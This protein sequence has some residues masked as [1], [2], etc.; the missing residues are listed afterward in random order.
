MFAE[1]NK[2]CGAVSYDSYLTLFKLYFCC[3]NYSDY[4]IMTEKANRALQLDQPAFMIL[5]NVFTC[6]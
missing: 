1:N 6:M 4:C 3:S 5:L 2:Y